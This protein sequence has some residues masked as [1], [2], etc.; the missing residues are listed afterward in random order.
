M[1]KYLFLFTLLTPLIGIYLVEDGE[2]AGSV[3]KDGH[4]NGAFEMFLVYVIIAITVA[5]LVIFYR[6]KRL[7]RIREKSELV[8]ENIHENETSYVV[9]SIAMMMF[10]LLLLVIF[11]F[12]FNAIGV[13][14]GSVDKGVFRTSL[15]SFGSIA[16][17][18]T[19]LTCPS[20]FAYATLL[21][22]KTRRKK[23][24]SLLWMANIFVLIILGSTWGF[25]TTGIMM[26]MPGFV[27]LFWKVSVRV[28][29]TLALGF[30][31]VIYASFQFFDVGHVGEVDPL[32]F[33]FHRLT[34]YQGDV[35]WLLWGKYAEG[36]DFYNYFPT[37]MAGFG[38]TL[39]VRI[40]DMDKDNLADWML[41]HYDYILNYSAGIPLH[42]IAGGHNVVGTPFSE[43]LIAGGVMGIII[44]A[45]IVGLI[46][47]T[48]YNLIKR[49]LFK[50]NKVLSALLATYFC[51]NVFPWLSGGGITML[52]HISN[53][54]GFAL[55]LAV[56]DV[57]LL[58]VK[59]MKLTTKQTIG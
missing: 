33:L 18:L 49:F 55:T 48:M 17:N 42:M 59:G 46:T 39:L 35:S 2:Y 26:L 1:F 12:F 53:L 23:M 13:W 20:L 3:G 11:L 51:F 7:N 34:I 25:K 19:K 10:N 14:M 44:F 37:L 45:G 31:A 9:F 56:L 29:L 8:E 57:L 41:Y 28:L 38:D 52:Y 24:H 5:L 50:S 58:V 43:G 22:M 21:F 32:T 4:P 40:A 47:G 36:G 6:K 15:G 27:L 54:F 30:S 16:Y